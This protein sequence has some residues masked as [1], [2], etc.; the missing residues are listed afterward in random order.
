VVRCGEVVLLV[1]DARADGVPDDGGQAGGAAD[2]RDASAL[3]EPLVVEL[4]E[5]QRPVV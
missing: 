1:A 3:A 4:G 5:D 2:L